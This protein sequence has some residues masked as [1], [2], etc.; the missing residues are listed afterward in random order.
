MVGGGG[1]ERTAPAEGMKRPRQ[2]GILGGMRETSKD[3]SVH[4]TDE[5]INTATH[6]AAAML[7]LFG[8]AYLIVEATM[9]A[10]VRHVVSLSVYAAS[11]FLLFLFS[12]L[13]HGIKAGRRAE[14]V[15]RTMDYLAI[16]PLIAGTYTPFCL[17]VIRGTL[18]WTVLGVVWVLA[19][20]GISL[21]AGM[22]SLA[23]WVTNTF[24]LTMGLMSLFLI[25][26]LLSLLPVSAIVLL[27]LGGVFY[28]GGNVVFTAEKPNP[29]PGRFGFH[30][31]WHLCVICGALSHYLIMLWYVL[32]YRL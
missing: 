4:V 10:S 32:P 15:L 30:E 18:G 20:V 13:H 21:K 5:I 22:S 19:A 2:N 14:G 3:G 17:V 11:L 27:I 25:V 1:G 28:V 9:E 16:F 23:K 8:G 31:I 26:P 6:M 7:A 12:S 24:Y 29:V